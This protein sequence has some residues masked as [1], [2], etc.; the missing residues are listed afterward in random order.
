MQINFQMFMKCPLQSDCQDGA[1]A[2]ASTGAASGRGHTDQQQA[3][4]LATGEGRDAPHT[5]QHTLLP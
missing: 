2:P 3:C 1:G 4:C 5:G